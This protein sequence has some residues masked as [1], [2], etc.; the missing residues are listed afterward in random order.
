MKIRLLRN[1][2]LVLLKINNT[3]NDIIKSEKVNTFH[4][5]IKDIIN[6]SMSS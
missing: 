2:D 3:S 4:M 5:I 6:L 1:L